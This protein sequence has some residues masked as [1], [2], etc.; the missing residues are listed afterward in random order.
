MQEISPK[1]SIVVPCYNQAHF[2]EECLLS[3]LKQS[4]DNWECII[5]NDGSP[6][7]TKEVAE[8][9]TKKD[10]RFIHHY[11]ENGGLASARNAGIKAAKG[12]Y[13]LPLDSDNKI[14]PDYVSES[15]KIMENDSAV[16]IVYSNRQKFGKQNYLVHVADFYFPE[17][18]TGNYIDACACYRKSIWEKLYGYDENMPIMGYEDWDFW[19]RSAINNAVFFHLDQTGFDYRVRNDSMLT[20]S[21]KNH[22]NIT[23]YM[24]NKK[25]LAIVKPVAD[26]YIKARQLDSMRWKLCDGIYQF[27]KKLLRPF[28]LA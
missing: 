25:E 10:K 12:K 18:C 17:I 8:Q 5:V 3:V 23:H 20:N 7:N 14:R 21:V 24:Y 9:F 13:I 22:E 4:Y 28:G 27:I 11:Q 6:D 2:L 16:D 19:L 1:V 26:L 15:I